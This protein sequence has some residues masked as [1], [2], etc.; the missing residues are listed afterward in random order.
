MD[1]NIV[2]STPPHIKGKR[3][4]KCIMLDVLIALIPAAVMGVVYFGLKALL[5]EA[6]A[7]LGAVATEFVYYFIA[8]G[9]FKD[10]CA[11]ALETCK[12]W[13]NQF[14]FTSAITGLILALI[15][16]VTVNWYE[17]LIGSVFAVA[18]VKMLFGGTGK[19]LVNP[20]ITGRIFMFISFTLTVFIAP[21]FEAIK[22]WD[23]SANLIPDDGVLQVGATVLSGNLLQGKGVGT[24]LLDLLLGSGVAGCIGE[25]CKVAI[26]AG[27][28]YLCARKIIKWWQPLLVVLSCGVLGTVL[29]SVQKEAFD[30]AFF[31]PS[32]LSGGLLFG[33]VFMATD[34]VTSPK[35][36]A[37]QVIYY[38]AIGLF[39]ALLRH[40]T[41]IEVISFTIM[42]LNLVVPLIDIYTVRKPFGYKK[43]S[44]EGK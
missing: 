31:L 13:L 22:W 38:V 26:I 8:Q 16:P 14:D 24:S 33:A 6:V 10:K 9:G 35:G 20:A 11:N 21:N 39:T 44:K 1:N 30:I 37:G 32:I 34:Y 43:T 25:T 12:K 15:V 29:M 28:I 7:I 19:N 5:L 42:L 36:F 27:Y 4:T 23:L 18:V 17:V 40:Y 3:T 2:I 41:K